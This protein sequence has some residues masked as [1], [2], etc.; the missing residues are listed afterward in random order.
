MDNSWAFDLETK[1]FSL[2]KYKTESRLKTT[3]P[4]IF[5]TTTNNPKD[6]ETHYPTVYIHELTGSEYGRNAEGDEINAILYS[7]QIEVTTNKS[8]KEAKNVLKE[9]A[10]AFKELGFEIQAFP[11]VSNTDSNYRSVMRVRKMIG[12]KD[13]L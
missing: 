5:F 9:V 3:Y 2:I 13:T 1:I 8:Q 11:E 7:S 6:V 4:N 12:N 10:I